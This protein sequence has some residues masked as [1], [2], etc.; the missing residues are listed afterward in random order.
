M[1]I[2]MIPLSAFGAAAVLHFCAL[3]LFPRLGLLDFPER[4]GLLR[5]R[6]PY[7]AGILSV[8][9]FLAFFSYLEIWNQEFF[10]IFTA[11]I[12]LAIIN[13]IDDRR[14]LP[15]SIRLF[16]QLFCAL[17]IFLMGTRIFTITNPLEGISGIP[18]I[19]LDTW[20]IPSVTFSNPSIIGMV[21]TMLWLGLTMNALNWFDG[22]RGQVSVVSLIGFLTIGALSLSDR[23]GD[24]HL[25]LLAF[26][27]AGIAAAGLFFDFPPAKVVMGDTGAMF[28]GLMLGVL[29]IYSG[30][31]VATG[32]LVLGVPLLDSII[33][34][35]RR[36]LKGKSPFR[37]NA[38]DEHLHHRLLRAGWSERQVIALTAVLGT[39]FGV[40]A[41][42]MDTLQKFLAGVA[43]AGIMM[44][45]SVYSGKKCT[46]RN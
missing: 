4:Y 20:V 43:L 14:P 15:F 12:L 18:H 30:G 40:A 17:V 13:F 21:F 46:M 36:V 35:L 3:R 29:T 10:G 26:I 25:A 41:L 33:V 5:K 1:D 38:I 42:F 11:V 8:C 9:T 28:F 23:V 32:F 2:W 31:K 24:E 37:G 22:I 45:L 34:G 39:S 44:V 16:V 19:A 27:L 7:P 6:L